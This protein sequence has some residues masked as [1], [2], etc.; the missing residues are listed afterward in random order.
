MTPLD[1]ARR[2]KAAG[3]SIFPVSRRGDKAPSLGDLPL[4]QCSDGIRRSWLP[5]TER[6]ATDDELRRW[7]DRPQPA[8]IAVV[9]GGVSGFLAVLDFET[10]EVFDRWAAC[11]S[12]SQKAILAPCPVI[13]TPG[14]GMHVYCRIDDSVGNSKL[15]LTAAGKTLI[16]IKAERGYVLA[17]GSP[18]CCHQTGRPYRLIR[19]GWID[20]SRSEPI[21]LATW[22]DLTILAADLNEYTRPTRVVGDA[23]E[24]SS[25]AQDGGNRPGDHFNDRIAWKDILG[26]HGWRVFRQRPKVTYW[27]RPDKAVKDG[28]SASTGFCMGKSG[29]DLLFVFSTSAAPFEARTSYSRFAA[30]AILSHHGDFRAAT[31]ALANA[32]YGEPR[33]A[34]A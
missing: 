23:P 29:R 27:T 14:G 30:Y 15:A 13:F 1:H 17:P 18:G 7:F 9:G 34:S 25:G 33:R 5:F 32:G 12:A 4:H 26:P 10:R 16:E 3:L 22:C 28:L 6:H 11:L 21:D 24:G 2:Y 19:A 8:G 31:L 20:G